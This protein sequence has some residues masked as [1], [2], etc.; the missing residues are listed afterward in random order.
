M[1]LYLALHIVMALLA[2][3]TLGYSIWSVI[4][5]NRILKEFKRKKADLKM[6]YLIVLRI[7]CA[8][9]LIAVAMLL[10][11]EFEDF[12]QAKSA[13]ASNFNV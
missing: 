9:C 13:K 4:D 1:K 8:E 3:F 12:V 11:L 2:I 10:S 5:T 6:I 7:A